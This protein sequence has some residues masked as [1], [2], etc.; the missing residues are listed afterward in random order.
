MSLYK[1]RKIENINYR[2]LN[3]QL[4][5]Q[6]ES[7]NNLWRLF[8]QSYSLLQK[9]T[10][11]SKV[12]QIIVPLFFISIGL[13]FIYQYLFP[14]IQTAVRSFAGEAQGTTSIVSD[15]FTELN[16]YIS[17]PGGLIEAS[18]DVISNTLTSVD[19]ISNNY[20]GS[21]RISIPA[22][23]IHSLPVEANVDSVNEAIYN[24]V[25]KKSLAHFENTSL[26]ISDLASNIVI[27][28]HSAT[29]VYNPKPT[30]P[31][32]AFSF[33]PNLK[34]GD[35]IFIEIEGKTYHYRMFKSKVVEPTDVSILA[36]TGNRETLT[37]FTCYP[38]GNDRS[39]Y[40]VVARPV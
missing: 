24:Q 33:L 31:E 28:G 40:V 3:D 26:P 10:N 15:N 16:L 1:Y 22:L 6:K 32:V 9:L 29:S 20:R 17:S 8:G 34:V 5:I 38:P 13:F 23:G 25:L 4:F 30:D 14:H 39:R 35:D 11:S 2:S 27:Y 36:G 7:P 21:F 12:A 18:N 19:S 37:L